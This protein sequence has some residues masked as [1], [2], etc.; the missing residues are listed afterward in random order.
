MLKTSSDKNRLCRL[1]LL[2]QTFW[3]TALLGATDI[4]DDLMNEDVRF[5]TQILRLDIQRREVIHYVLN[6]R[7][8]I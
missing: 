2:L 6:G 5:D 1:T 8:S 3:R 4:P 7:S